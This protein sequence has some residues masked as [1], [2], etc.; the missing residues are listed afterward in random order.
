[1]ELRLQQNRNEAA[2]TA[3]G[4]A[5]TQGEALPGL[6][7]ETSQEKEKGVLAPQDLSAGGADDP[8]PSI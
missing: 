7:K 3:A 5:L 6:S 4:I 8:A 2:P 1:M